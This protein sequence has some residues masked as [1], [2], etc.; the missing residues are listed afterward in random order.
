MQRAENV[1]NEVCGVWNIGEYWR[2]E[3]ITK[4]ADNNGVEGAH[5]HP[6]HQVR[7]CTP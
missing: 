7:K 3:Y 6:A 1:E 5:H 4:T 2:V